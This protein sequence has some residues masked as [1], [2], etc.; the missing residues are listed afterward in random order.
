MES[1][2]KTPTKASAY[3]NNPFFVAINGIELIFKKAQTIAIILI[4]ISGL[5]VLASIPSTF[6]PSDDDYSGSS[7]SYMDDE[8]SSYGDYRNDVDDKA[9]S[10]AA[11]AGIVGVIVIIA[12]IV[13]LIVAFIGIVFSGISDYTAAQLSHGKDVPLGEAFRAVFANFWPYTWV[14]VVTGFKIFLWTLLFII[15]GIIMAVRY[16]LSGVVYF[17]KKLKGNASVKESARLTKGLWLTT[18]A[19]QSLFNA[20]TLGFMELLLGPGTRA[21]LYRQYV[22]VDAS[23]APKPPAHILSWLTLVLPL[24]LFLLLILLLVLLS[25]II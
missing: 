2:A 1:S 15:P 4:V 20:L 3:E 9:S 13:L 19:S 22:A 11:I 12:I 5:S 25:A 16:S 6:V 24:T 8:Y 21:I 23:G 10:P 7:S 17:D 14:L 18:F